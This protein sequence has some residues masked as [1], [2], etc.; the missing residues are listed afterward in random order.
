MREYRRAARRT[1]AEFGGSN[2]R[3]APIIPRMLIPNP[4]CRTLVAML[5]SRMTLIA[6][7]LTAAC[8]PA[9]ADDGGSESSGAEVPTGGNFPDTALALCGPLPNGVVAIDDLASAHAATGP[10]PSGSNADATA[11][12]LRLSSWGVD[13]D[14]GFPSR[15][16]SDPAC[17]PGWAVAFDLSA[18][19]AV[20]T[21]DIATIA[22]EWETDEIDAGVDG[23]C[24]SGGGEV[25][26]DGQLEVAG[27][28]E[29][30]AVTDT[31]IVGELSGIAPGTAGLHDGGFAAVRAELPCVPTNRDCG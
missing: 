28:L 14:Q 2:T 30:F 29:I 10:R 26:G 24:F 23:K 6:L 15:S 13:A 31:C 9:E 11:V 27:T 18:A 5:V 16:P 19:P 17:T 8:D 21:L 4:A 12:R 7:L 25:G 1:R 22:G 20:G 3:A